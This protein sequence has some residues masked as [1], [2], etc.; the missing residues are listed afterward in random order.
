MILTGYAGFTT[1]AGYVGPDYRVD[2]DVSM[3][4]PEIW[5][6][7]NAYEREPSFLLEN[8]LL[9]KIEDFDYEGQRILASRLG[10]RITEVFCGAFSRSLV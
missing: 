6:R 3:L 9:E 2:H 1:A 5:C 8:G 10:Y 7:M 4:V